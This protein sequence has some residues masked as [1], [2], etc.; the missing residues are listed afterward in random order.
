MQPTK[1]FI[2]TSSQGIYSI[3]AI[4]ITYYILAFSLFFQSLSSIVCLSKPFEIS[5]MYWIHLRCVCFALQ[6]LLCV[7]RTI[8][9]VFPYNISTIR[10]FFA[11]SKLSQYFQNEY[12]FARS[13]MISFVTVLFVLDILHALH[14]YFVFLLDGLV[15]LNEVDLE[16]VLDPLKVDVFHL[17]LILFD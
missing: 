7:P 14:L 9:W 17:H 12:F 4:I 10:C 11:S 5:S 1:P 15:R 16:A 8:T 6:C 2:E 13:G 3:R